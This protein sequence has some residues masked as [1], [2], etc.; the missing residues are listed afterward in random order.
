MGHKRRKKEMSPLINLAIGIG[1]RLIDNKNLKSKTNATTVL[2]T[3]TGTGAAY[4][5]MLASDDIK[6]Q[7]MGMILTLATLA[8]AAYKES[9]A[10]ETLD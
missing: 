9:H 10:V 3:L 7:A 5:F 1:S 6:V 4:T 8:L 2:A